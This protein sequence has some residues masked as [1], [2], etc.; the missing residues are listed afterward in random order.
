MKV[1]AK[2]FHDGKGNRM[3]FPCFMYK[4][5]DPDIPLATYFWS[6][7]LQLSVATGLEMEDGWLEFD[8]EYFP[9][10]IMDVGS[11]GFA[12]GSATAYLFDGPQFKEIADEQIG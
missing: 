4:V 11:R 8:D 9:H 6:Y 7:G 5:D 3:I 1:K 10:F 12:H 2:V